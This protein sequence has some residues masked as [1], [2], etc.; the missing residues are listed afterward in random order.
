MKGNCKALLSPRASAKRSCYVMHMHMHKRIISEAWLIL[1]VAL[2]PWISLFTECTDEYTLQLE[3]TLRE[4]VAV[5]DL[6]KLSIPI[7]VRLLVWLNAFSGGVLG[8]MQ[9]LF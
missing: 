4:S 9:P 6:W 1:H 5:I 8:E 7:T 3:L 2:Q